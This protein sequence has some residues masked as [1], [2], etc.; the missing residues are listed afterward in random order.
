M[1]LMARVVGEGRATR[2]EVDPDRRR[3]EFEPLDGSEP[4]VW[5]GREWIIMDTTEGVRGLNVPPRRIV[6]DEYPEL[7]GARIR[8]VSTGPRVVTVP[9][10]IAHDGY[11]V[12]AHQAQL[13]R[14]RQ[15]LDYRLADV[16]ATDGTF[17]LVAVGQDGSSRRLRCLYQ[18]GWAG[19]HSWRARNWRWMSRFELELVAVDPYWRGKSWTT[20]VVRLPSP[21]PFLSSLP[22]NT[23]PRRLARSTALGTAMSVPVGGDVGTGWTVALTGPSTGPV[24][25]S[26]TGIDIHVSALAAGD[27]LVISYGRR[28]TITLNGAPAGAVI[29]R[30]AAWALMRPGVNQ[31]TITMPGATLASQGRMWGEDRWE[32]AFLGTR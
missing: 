6:L 11:D 12:A 23:W 5:A 19:N 8:D 26:S 32:T 2:V 22:G 18:G 4:L 31:V 14:V 9:I 20:P 15:L 13:A 16:H 30:G 1:P 21:T 3:L 28:R 27:E 10:M 7:D 25:Q 24:I 17:D 29:A